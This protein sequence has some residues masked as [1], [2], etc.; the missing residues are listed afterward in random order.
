M[1]GACCK[2]GQTFTSC[3]AWPGAVV[4]HTLCLGDNRGAHPRAA[5]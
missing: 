3:R 5:L 4:W 1:T 2:S